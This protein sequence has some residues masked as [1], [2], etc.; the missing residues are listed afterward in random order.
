MRKSLITSVML[1]ALAAP[2]L[3]LAADAAPEWTLTSN[4]GV[5]SQYIFRG[6]TQTNRNT[7]LQGGADLG[8]SSGFYA[9]IWASNISWLRDNNA[10]TPFYSEGGSA[11]IDLY[12]GFKKEISNTGIT[13]DVGILQY[14]YPGTRNKTGYSSFA[15]T[16]ELYGALNYGWVQGKISGVVSRDAWEWGVQNRT[17]ED[18]RGT[19]Y[20]EFNATVPVGDLAGKNAPVLSGISLIAHIGRQEF[21]GDKATT[22]YNG[23]CGT[24]RTNCNNNGASY[25]D[26]K[27]GIQKAFGEGLLNGT[28]IGAFATYADEDNK[29]YWNTTAGNFR[30]L[31]EAT[32]TAFIQRTF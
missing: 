27:L 17:G 4:V 16:T 26:Y 19:Y 14:Y 31:G 15:N 7:A 24:N 32:G 18:A 1:G 2:S 13:A 10:G 3:V 9:G 28:T 5:F 30:N 11:E 21:Q 23:Y 29:G 12:G 25:T 22:A 8:H 20:A 6:M